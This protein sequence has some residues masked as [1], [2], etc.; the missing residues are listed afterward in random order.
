MGDRTLSQA[1]VSIARTR[2][3]RFLWAAWWNEAPAERPFRKPDAHGGGA[4]TYEDALRDAERITGRSLSVIEP[5]WA[6]AWSRVMQGERPWDGEAPG[7]RRAPADE[8]S[9]PRASIWKVLGLRPDASVEDI[10]RA[11]RA[12]AKE[13]HPDQGGDAETFRALH[14]AYE[15]ALVRRAKR[16]L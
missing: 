2:R 4:R 13:T 1:V 5:R 7:A 14:R 16:P 8:R 12:R 9:A 3:R 6:R 10:K 15:R 11:Y